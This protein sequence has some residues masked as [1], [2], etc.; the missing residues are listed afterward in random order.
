MNGAEHPLADLFARIPEVHCTGE[1]GRNRFQTCCGPIPCTVLEAELLEEFDGIRC[2]WKQLGPVTVAMDLSAD[3]GLI[4]PHLGIGGRCTAYEAR[5]IVCRL[6][7]AV[8]ALR[9]PW[10]CKPDRLL[11][12]REVHEIMTEA[13]HRSLVL[14]AQRKVNKLVDKL[15]GPT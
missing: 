4:C 2:A 8:K 1:C 7:G 14:L 3:L 15:R 10:G 12:E 11:S 13:S 9:C 6:W 5:P